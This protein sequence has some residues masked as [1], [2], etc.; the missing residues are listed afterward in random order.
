MIRGS[1]TH[2]ATHDSAY[3][4]D[5]TKMLDFITDHFDGLSE[6]EAETKRDRLTGLSKGKG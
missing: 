1:I 6:G 3:F 2:V 4:P 5:F